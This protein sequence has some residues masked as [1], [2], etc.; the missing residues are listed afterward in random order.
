MAYAR[1]FPA[2]QKTFLKR[3]CAATTQPALDTLTGYVTGT[4]EDHIDLHLPYGPDAA[5]GYPFTPGMRFELSCEAQGMGL[6]LQ[7][8]FLE[9]I[10][11][12]SIRLRFDGNLEFI[13][14]RHYR[15]VDV[16]A[17]VGLDRSGGSLATRRTEWQ[18]KQRQLQEGVS[19][20]RL[21]KFQKVTLNL[22]GGGLRLAV[23]TPVEIA[24]LI[25]IFLSIGDRGGIICA[26]A[27]VVWLGA[28]EADG[29]RSAGLRF[30][31]LL[32]EDQARIDRVV[33]ALLE[34]LEQAGR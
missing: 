27:E 24:E 32:S 33:T 3:L 15:R 29:T 20:A 8:S 25:V 21:T 16:I 14:L 2:G 7:A 22:S 5:G 23:A 31:N 1:Y 13:S 28:V 4:G 18:E 11:S 10:D 6:R 9:W 30:L 34:R 26:L 17:W 12:T 19:A